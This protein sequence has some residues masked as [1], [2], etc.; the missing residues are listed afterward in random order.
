[1]IIIVISIIFFISFFFFFFIFIITSICIHRSS[2]RGQPRSCNQPR[3]HSHTTAIQSPLSCRYQW[4]SITT[5]RALTLSQLARRGIR[6]LS[7]SLAMIISWFL[8]PS[9]GS[10]SG[11]RLGG[12]SHYI[13]ARQI[14]LLRGIY[15]DAVVLIL[16]IST[17]I[18]SQVRPLAPLSWNFA[19]T[20][21]KIHSKC[22][23]L[24]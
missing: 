4:V 5:F 10:L 14:S 15:Y 2:L 23:F 12:I 3:V 13:T 1:M 19:Q 18:H 17:L 20:T 16:G 7:S 22:A 6:R 21:P 11:G 9:W 8:F 24:H